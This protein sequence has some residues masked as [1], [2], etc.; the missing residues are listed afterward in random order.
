MEKLLIGVIILLFIWIIV[1]TVIVIKILG[2]M[3]EK[4][5]II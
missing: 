3:I 1:L 4:G 5:W 2:F